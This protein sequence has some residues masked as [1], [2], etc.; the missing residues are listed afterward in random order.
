MEDRTAWVIPD[1]NSSLSE[2]FDR[3]RSFPDSLFSCCV[4]TRRWQTL[5]LKVSGAGE[6]PPCA[7]SEPD[8]NLS[9]HPAPIIQPLVSIPIASAETDSGCLRAIRPSQYTALVR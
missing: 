4:V 2:D 6:L 3:D 5:E 7:L 1:V 9:T 8:L